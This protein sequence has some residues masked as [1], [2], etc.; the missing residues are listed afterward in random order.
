MPAPLRYQTRPKRNPTAGIFIQNRTQT[1]ELPYLMLP[2]KAGRHPE[3]HGYDKGLCNKALGIN[4]L[5]TE[6]WQ[7]RRPTNFPPTLPLP[8]L[9]QYC[10]VRNLNWLWGTR[11]F[12]K[13]L[14]ESS[15]WETGI[16]NVFA[17]L[18]LSFR[19]VSPFP[20]QDLWTP[21]NWLP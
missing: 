18:P 5:Q 15:C 3:Q 11:P 1:Q 16:R 12:Y 7:V 2:S 17:K 10:L 8:G 19:L 14:I 9:K 4:P 21:Q 6:T 13:A 20:Y